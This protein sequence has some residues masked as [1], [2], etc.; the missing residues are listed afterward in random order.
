MKKFVIGFI[1]MV[2]GIGFAFTSDA[3]VFLDAYTLTGVVVKA[4]R[5][6]PQPYKGCYVFS[7]AVQKESKMPV[8]FIGAY[9]MHNTQSSG[10]VARRLGKFLGQR[11]FVVLSKVE[12]EGFVLATIGNLHTGELILAA[13]LNAPNTIF[14]LKN[15]IGDMCISIFRVK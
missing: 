10:V 6:S 1:L 9:Y 13:E 8:E 14:G 7:R 5:N 15:G 3:E 12:D 11:G 4:E 2:F